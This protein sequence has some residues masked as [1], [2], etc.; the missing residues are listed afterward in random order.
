[1]NDKEVPTEAEER[2]RRHGTTA[3]SGWSKANRALDARMK[4]LL[5][6]RLKDWRLHDL[7]RTCATGMEDA[8]IATHVVETALNQDIVLG[9]LEQ[10][11]VMLLAVGNSTSLLSSTAMTWA[12]AR[13]LSPFQRPLASR[14]STA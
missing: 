6:P 7:R 8:G 14:N 11:Y 4:A 12:T 2:R 5:G 3:P 1:M 13:R 9:G 10:L